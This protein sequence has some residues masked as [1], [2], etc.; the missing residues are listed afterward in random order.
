MRL[1]RHSVGNAEKGPLRHRLDHFIPVILS[2]GGSVSGHGTLEICPLWGLPSLPER[3]IRCGLTRMAH[4]GCQRGSRSG[5]L[6]PN[7][8][9]P[10]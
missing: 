6:G 8:E 4:V 7:P 9:S 5:P 3:V 1:E 10:C 2:L